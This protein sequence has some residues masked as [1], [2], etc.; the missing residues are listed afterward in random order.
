MRLL[1]YSNAPI[2]TLRPIPPSSDHDMKPR[3]LWVSV[4]GEDDWESWCKSEQFALDRLT[5]LHEVTLT[6]DANILRISDAD[7]IFELGREYGKSPSW[8]GRDR[9]YS[10]DW[11]RLAARWQGLLIAPYQWSCRLHD[12]C[13][14]YYGWDCASGCIWDVDAIATLTAT[15]REA[16]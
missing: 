11:P 1:H 6:P 13:F 14:W 5:V 3:G 12:Q 16:V 9:V 7:A 2:E 4:E 10:L 8:A 15:K